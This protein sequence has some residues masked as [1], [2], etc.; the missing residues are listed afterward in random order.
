[1]IVPTCESQKGGGGYVNSS[2]DRFS[3]SCWGKNC[4]VESSISIKGC[5]RKP[6]IA[7]WN[8]LKFLF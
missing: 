3:C 6:T 2:F 8:I 5:C 4:S 1:M 7:T